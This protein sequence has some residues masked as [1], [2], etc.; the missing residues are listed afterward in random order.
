MKKILLASVIAI[1]S[2]T[3][4]ATTI[5]EKVY[6]VPNM[7]ASSIEQAFGEKYMNIEEGTTQKFGKMLNLIA[8]AGASSFGN[9]NVSKYN[10]SCNWLG[11]THKSK[12]DIVVLTKDNK[13]KVSISNVIME[14]GFNFVDSGSK[15]FKKKCLKDITAWAD[16][17]H[18]QML[19][20]ND[21]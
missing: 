15:S 2:T 3:A 19:K 6:Q 4:S 12:A 9:D 18:V 17:K 7:S 14:S 5:F 13:Y 8:S 21:F 11:T 20:M 10:I 16:N 1:M